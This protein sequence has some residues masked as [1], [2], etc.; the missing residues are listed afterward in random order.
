MS[1]GE[2]GAGSRNEIRERH[3]RPRTRPRTGSGSRSG[4]RRRRSGLC[5][6]AMALRSH[7]KLL[8]ALLLPAVLAMG[9]AQGLLFMRCGESV[10]MSCC[11][12]H[13]DAPPP[14]AALTQAPKQCCDKLAV[15]NLPAQAHEL[16][17]S[18]AP[19]P[20]LVAVLGAE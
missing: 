4:C 2:L 6:G 5:L 3:P 16:A 15:P 11:C 13:E 19:A 12:P 14:A 20:V 8:A 7:S 10:R 9:A 18:P 1:G 17:T